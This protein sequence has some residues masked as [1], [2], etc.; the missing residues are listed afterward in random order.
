MLTSIAAYK[1]LLPACVSKAKAG[2]V[3]NHPKLFCLGVP[4]TI[5][6]TV[7]YIRRKRWHSIS[8]WTLAFSFGARLAGVGFVERYIDDPH[9]AT[10]ALRILQTMVKTDK[11][12]HKFVVELGGIETTVKAMKRYSEA[13]DGVAASGSGLICAICGFDTSTDHK[14]MNCGAIR[15]L[16]EAMEFWPNNEEVQAYASEA[17][18]RLAAANQGSDIQ[19]KIIDVGGLVALAKARTK[20]QH[21]ARVN[22]PATSAIL[23]LVTQEKVKLSKS[24][25]S[26]PITIWQSYV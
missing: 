9:D 26:G 22:S 13:F 6:C 8:K 2:Y 23:L 20:H 10:N 4:A 3:V 11:H 18:N 7:I 21:D 24:W 19:K 14:L 12:I 1:V 16:V 15:V 25:S 17:L 5:A